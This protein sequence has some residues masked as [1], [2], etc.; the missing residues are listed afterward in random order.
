[1]SAP[2]TSIKTH[3]PTAT[4]RFITA[5]LK[6]TEI[7]ALTRKTA[8]VVQANQA[9]AQN[10]AL[11]QC[12]TSWISAGDA[13]DHNEQDLTNA[14]SL[15]TLTEAKRVT[16][17][18]DW[19]RETKRVLAEI[20][21]LAGGSPTDVK[22]WGF[23]LTTRTVAPPTTDAPTGLRATYKRDLSMV[24]RWKA[25]RSNRGYALQIG[26]GT[27]TGWGP[28]IQCPTSKY[29]PQGLTP[30]QHIAVRVAVQRKTGLS[31]WSDAVSV[32]AH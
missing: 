10:A 7:A 2:K 20:D 4:P 23:E 19:K 25:I 11:Q 8:Q 22:A 15:V 1:M 29:A 32:V 12:V 9:Y 30:G 26:D 21:K 28:T 27:P 5:G 6:P 13:V 17:V 24:I 14:K 31:V 16:F 18:N 3:E